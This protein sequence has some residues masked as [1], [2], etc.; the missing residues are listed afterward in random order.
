MWCVL[1]RSANLC[2]LLGVSSVCTFNV[3][4]ATVGFKFDILLRVS[5]VLY[6]L[7]LLFV[8]GFHLD[9]FMLFLGVSP[10]VFSVVLRV[11]KYTYLTCSC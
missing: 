11:L 6:F 8:L 5:F 10:T 1:V 2:L 9:L 3:T 4:A 7:L